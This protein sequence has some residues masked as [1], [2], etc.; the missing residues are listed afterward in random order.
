MLKQ[1]AG[2]ALPVVLVLTG[3]E[4]RAHAQATGPIPLVTTQP[5][6]TTAGSTGTAR[7]VDDTGS[8]DLYD[9]QSSPHHSG[10]PGPGLPWQVPAST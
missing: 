10:V 7:P 5:G 8:L 2:V 9:H 3:A 4:Q 1:V 6:T